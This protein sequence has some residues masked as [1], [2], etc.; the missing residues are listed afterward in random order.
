MIALTT[1]FVQ[2]WLFGLCAAGFE[3]TLFDGGNGLWFMM[4]AAIIG[5][6]FQAT[7]HLSR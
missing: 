4:S 7:A 2:I 1:L 5:L 3:S 6:R